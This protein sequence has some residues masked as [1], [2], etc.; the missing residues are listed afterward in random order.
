MLAANPTLRALARGEEVGE[1]ELIEL[2]RQLEQE[3]G[4]PDLQLSPG[5]IHRAYALRVGCLL[6][7]LRHVLEVGDIPDYV[8][9]VRRQFEAFIAG[10]AFNADQILFLRTLQSVLAQR[11]RLTW[12]SCTN[13]PLPLWAPTP[14]TAGSPRT[15]RKRSW[16]SPRSLP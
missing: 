6:E 16:R 4:A 12:A 2:E 5:T 14:S 10:H 15:S 13:R 1:G 7:F 11:H 3:L 8:E 9:I